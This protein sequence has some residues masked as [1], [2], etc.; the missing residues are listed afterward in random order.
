MP[1][2]GAL[3][4]LKEAPADGESIWEEIGA[5][6]NESFPV[7]NGTKHVMKTAAEV[8]AILADKFVN[9]ALTPSSTATQ[10]IVNIVPSGALVASAIWK[11]YVID[12]AALDPAGVSTELYGLDFDFSGVDLTNDPS[13]HAI[14]ITMPASYTGES[15]M[16]GAHFVGNGNVVDIL[17]NNG[18]ALLVEGEIQQNFDAGTL[19]AAQLLP[20]ND[21]VI[22][23]SKATGGEIH[24]FDIVEQDGGNASVTAIAIHDDIAP[25]HQHLG[26]YLA[27]TQGLTYDASL[28]T[29][30]DVT[31][32]INADDAN[33]A[34]VFVEDNDL[35]YIGYTS[36]FD[37]IKVVLDTGANT[38]VNPR[39]DYVTGAATSTQFT[40]IDN[41][42]GFENSGTASWNSDG[43]TSW[44]LVSENDI[45]GA[46]SVDD[47][48]WIK[49][50]RRQNVVAIT[51]IVNYVSVLPAGSEFYEWDENGDVSVHEVTVVKSKITPEGGFAELLVNKTGAA[52]VVGKTVQIEATTDSAVDIC[53]ADGQEM[54]GAMYEA[55]IADG[56]DVWVVTAGRAQVLLK[57]ATAG[58][59]GYWVKTSDVAG[60]VDATNA[61][62]P[63]G[64]VVQIDTHMQECGHC[65]QTIGAGTDVLCWIQMH[66]N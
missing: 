44:A 48:Y 28:A 34:A 7:G 59:R 32:D 60:R 42:S 43:F 30:A 14:N 2:N 53:D 16:C 47:R 54:I 26:D 8:A 51:P 20:I 58:T 38:D 21:L 37:A 39:W 17:C 55:G 40:P 63:G 24:V 65:M 15:S 50:K 61:A 66:F 35:L 6:A 31:S 41:T 27:L 5:P 9:I 3:V 23:T 19:A 4:Q 22:D 11:G 10:T 25:I 1:T 45:T 49:L 52:S 57:D 12:A 13:I 33:S 62:P 56:D 18:N 29:Y 46:G 36:K 64:G